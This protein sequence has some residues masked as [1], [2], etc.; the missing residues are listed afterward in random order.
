MTRN[1]YTILVLFYKAKKPGQKLI[2][3]L[4]MPFALPV[5]GD[6][7]LP[8]RKSFGISRHHPGRS[9]PFRL[10]F[11]EHI[12]FKERFVKKIFGLLAG[13]LM[14]GA[15]NA[16]YLVVEGGGAF[17]DIGAKKTAQTLANLSGQ[18]VTYSYNRGFV[19]GRVAY[20]HELDERFAVELGY[21]GASGLK[22]TYTIS[23]ASAT[24]SYSSAGIDFSGVLKL[25]SGLFVK[26]GFHSSKLNGAASITIGGTTYS[27]SGRVGSGTG[28]LFGIGYESELDKNS[29]VRVGWTRY[30]AVGG[31]TSADADFVYGAYV[32]KF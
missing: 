4:L 32:I 10:N 17:S 3:L 29:A 5:F 25:D 7:D 23:G 30:S 6:T 28:A 18:T 24:E 31:V 14:A 15:V 16:Q 1:I 11:A 12:S 21:F 19:T 13:L 26:G 20:G 9:V 22:A 8:R 2:V 27:V